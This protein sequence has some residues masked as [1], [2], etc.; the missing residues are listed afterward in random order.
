M[1]V[2]KVSHESWPLAKALTISRGVRR[3]A[4][5]VVVEIRDG[6]ATGRG[7]CMP[8]AHYGES[9]PAVIAEIEALRGKIADGLECAALQ[10]ALPPGAARNALDCALWDLAAKQAG[11]PVWRLAG[12]DAPAPV[13]TAYTLGVDTPAAMAAAAK[14][15]AWRPF[16]KLKLT[17]EG[18]IGRVEAVRDAAPETKLI[19]DANEGWSPDMVE[20]FSA[21]LAR[22]NVV[23]IEQPLPASADSMLA[24]CAHPVP[25]CADESCHA[26]DTLDLLAGRYDMINIKLDKTGGLS[27]ALV[28]RDGARARGLSVM[29]GCMVA[30]SLS[31]APAMLVAQGSQ[32]VDLDGPLLLASDRPNGLHYDGSTVSPPDPALW[33]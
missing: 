5:V 7:E 13:V 33:G 14:E 28:L 31:M 15:N 29:I 24:D 4:E 18:D 10:S 16:L 23:M 26:S 11:Q 19:V 17:G 6:D 3:S 32:I 25:I 30:T 20:P 21:E 12:L 8:Y 1:R 9:V 2:L 22:L 27:E